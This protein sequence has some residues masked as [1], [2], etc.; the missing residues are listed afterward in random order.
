MARKKWGDLTA[1]QHKGLI[2]AGVV[3]LVLAGAAW[4][5]LAMR[6]GEFVR[7][8]KLWWALTI[9]VSFAGPL[10]YFRWGRKI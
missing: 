2:A 6:P 4:T 1:A 5:D 8:R 10:T 9:L 7:G 3:Q